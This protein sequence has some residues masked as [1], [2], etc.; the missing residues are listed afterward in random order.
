MTW[1]AVN[2]EMRFFLV[3]AK[4]CFFPALFV[5]GKTERRA[6]FGIRLILNIIELGIEC[7]G[8]E[9]VNCY[10]YLSRR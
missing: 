4:L 5:S 2:D 9:F 3:A 6:D 10:C 7:E 8:L 1:S